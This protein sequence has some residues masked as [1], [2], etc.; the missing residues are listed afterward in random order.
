MLR[1]DEVLTSGTPQVGK[2]GSFVCA[3]VLCVCCVPGSTCG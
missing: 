2:V 1:Y 3:C